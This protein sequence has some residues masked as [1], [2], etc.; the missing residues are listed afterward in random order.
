[1]RLVAVGLQDVSSSSRSEANPKVGESGTRAAWKH[2][3][4]GINKA[5]VA[6]TGVPGG[7]ALRAAVEQSVSWRVPVTR[8]GTWRP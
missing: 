1:V 6:S 7:R 2:E 8:R 3:D 4:E 5:E